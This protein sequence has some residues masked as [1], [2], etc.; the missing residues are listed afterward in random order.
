MDTGPGYDMD[1]RYNNS[2]KSRTRQH[3]TRIH[4][5]HLEC[6]EMTRGSGISTCMHT[7]INIFVHLKVHASNNII[8]FDDVYMLKV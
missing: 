4:M 3:N 8:I 1:M 7:Y 5:T 2:L 6:V